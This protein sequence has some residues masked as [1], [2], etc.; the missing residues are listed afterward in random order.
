MTATVIAFPDAIERADREF[1][2]TGSSPYARLLDEAETLSAAVKPADFAA[3][4]AAFRVATARVI[5]DRPDLGSELIFFGDDGRLV[6]FCRLPDAMAGPQA[7]EAN[8]ERLSGI[9]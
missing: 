4:L 5:H 6:E 2:R 8:C 1:E 3:R 9:S 7:K